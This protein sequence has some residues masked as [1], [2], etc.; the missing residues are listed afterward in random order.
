MRNVISEAVH[1]DEYRDYLSRSGR[2]LPKV[3]KFTS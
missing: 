2:F 3:R 1:G